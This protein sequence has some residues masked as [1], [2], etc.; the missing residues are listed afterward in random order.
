MDHIQQNWGSGLFGQEQSNAIDPAGVLL[1]VDGDYVYDAI[2][3]DYDLDDVIDTVY[4]DTDQNGQYDVMAL[5]AD[6]DGIFENIAPFPQADESDSIPSDVTNEYTNEIAPD[7]VQE[8]DTDGDL[9]T[10]AQ[11]LSYD[12]DDNNVFDL[13]EVKTYGEENSTYNTT[14]IFEYVDVD[15]DALPDQVH[16]V[17][18]VN[19]DKVF[20]IY[21]EINAQGDVVH[22]EYL[23]ED[24]VSMAQDTAPKVWD[25]YDAQTMDDSQIIGDVSDLEQWEFQ[26]GNT[27]GV[28]AQKFVIEQLT[29]QEV[30]IND[31]V[32]QAMELDS[33]D[34]S[35]GTV[36]YDVDALL[37]RYGLDTEMKQNASV[38]D[39][40][41]CIENDG[42]VIAFVDSD[43]IWSSDESASFVSNDADH[44]VQVV[45]IDYSNPDEPMVILN[46]S[47]HP[48]GR[49]EMVP[50]STFVDAW[51]DGGC[52]MVGAYA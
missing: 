50:L 45:G 15:D 36:I 6:R 27:C 51:E 10:D 18:D 19:N 22:Y 13:I 17:L 25:N 34:P 4:A 31:L 43:E 33:Y 21:Q 47:G 41:D 48:H 5:D 49:G 26:D 24:Y 11:V 32:D 2:G 16:H 9:I 14:E 38:Q 3:Y 52:F 37:Q 8:V 12:M 30:P 42:K 7:S 35:Q 46:D 39:M 40:L 29:G 20:D 1:D 23:T 44:F 28:F